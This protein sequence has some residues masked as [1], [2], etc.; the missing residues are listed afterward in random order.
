[1]VSWEQE[2]KTVTLSIP[3]GQEKIF[4]TSCWYSMSYF[5]FTCEHFTCFRLPERRKREEE[6]NLLNRERKKERKEEE[7]RKMME[8]SSK[9]EDEIEGRRKWGRREKFIHLR[10]NILK[11][12]SFRFWVSFSSLSSFFL[13]SVSPVFEPV[14]K[15]I[16]CPCSN[17]NRLRM[18]HR[19]SPSLFLSFSFSSFFSLSLTLSLSLDSH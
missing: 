12:H 17:S 19:R 18:G 11:N 8:E 10:I 9:L 6:K 3:G 5:I 15:L 1:M 7:K 14:F 13:L 16:C 2:E 4:K